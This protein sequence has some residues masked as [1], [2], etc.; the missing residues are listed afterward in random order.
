M[1]HGAKAYH[2]TTV[3]WSDAETKAFPL[4]SEEFDTD[5]YHSTVTD[6]SRMT[7][8]AGLAGYYWVHAAAYIEGDP[9]QDAP[10]SILKNYPGTG[11]GATYVVRGSATTPYTAQPNAVGGVTD[12]DCLVYLAEGDYVEAFLYV[13]N[14][15]GGG[16]YPVGGTT[17]PGE[18]MTLSVARIGT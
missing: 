6:N 15:G 8:P 11:S 2:D 5:G 12:V 14:D 10:T 13:D 1:F 17:N 9:A 16:S 18:Q 7:I 3:A 4:N